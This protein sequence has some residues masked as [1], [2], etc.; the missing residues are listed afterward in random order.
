MTTYL[1]VRNWMRDTG[2]RGAYLVMW[3]ILAFGLIAFLGLAYDGGEKLHA[4]QRVN[5]IAEEAA[6]TAGQQIVRPVGVRGIATVAD[7]VTAQ[8]AAQTYLAQFPDV[9]GVVIPTGPTTLVVVT[10]ATW[11]PKIVSMLGVGPA[12]I[13]GRAVIN[14]NRTNNGTPGL[15]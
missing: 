3:T 8:I 5:H 12:Q 9:H 13:E 4:H 10:T 14:L 7:P 1:R 6:R 2:T 15:P 11:T